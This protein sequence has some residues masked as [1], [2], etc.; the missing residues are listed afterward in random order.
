MA[1]MKNQAILLLVLLVAAA[2]VALPGGAGMS[3]CA[4]QTT[5][6]KSPGTSPR[7]A[8]RPR[9]LTLSERIRGI[10][11]SVSLERL[12]ESVNALAGFGSRN[13]FAQPAST[14]QGIGGARAWILERLRAISKENGGR[15]QVSEDPFR[16][17]LPKE[18]AE[19]LGLEDVDAAN[20]VAILPGG[21]PASRGRILL[22]GANYDS[23]NEERYDI[24]NPAPGADANGSGVALVLELASVLSPHGFDATIVFALFAGKEQGLWGSSHFAANAKTDRLQIEAVIINDSV[25]H[26]IGGDGTTD[27]TRVRCF[28]PGPSDGASRELA[29]YVEERGEAYVPSF[30]VRM[31]F[32]EDRVNRAG[33][34]LSFQKQG[35]AAVRLSEEAENHERKSSPDDLPEYVHLPYLASVARVNAAAA[36]SLAL[37]P[38]RAAGV[39]RSWEASHYDTRLVWDVPEDVLDLEGFKILVRETTSPRWQWEVPIGKTGDV[40]LKGISMDVFEFAVVTVDREGNESLAAPVR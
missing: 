12:G 11:A 21:S 17:S 14:D 15:L 4:A 35:F 28:S 19:K 38:P 2:G 31:V 40:T 22:I 8:W 5:D 23:R 20:L 18:V 34:Q 36:A 32:R 33:D 7:A 27:G 26:V 10:V 37:A 39:A 13:T 9:T 25:G 1:A 16:T 29:R 24:T 30:E 3:S 6:P